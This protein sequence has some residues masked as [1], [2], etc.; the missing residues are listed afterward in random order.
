MLPRQSPHHRCLSA[1]T[2]SNYIV[3]PVPPVV[4]RQFGNNLEAKKR[5]RGTIDHRHFGGGQRN[6]DTPPGAAGW[7]DG[8]TRARPGCSRTGTAPLCAAD[9]GGS[10]RVRAHADRG[11]GG[12]AVVRSFSCF[13]STVAVLEDVKDRIGVGRRRGPSQTGA[14]RASRCVRSSVCC[15]ERRQIPSFSEAKTEGRRSSNCLRDGRTP[16]SRRCICGWDIPRVYR[17]CSIS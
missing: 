7:T 5:E 14:G 1:I 12:R 11:Q 8:R 16:D 10:E 13:A 3:Q 6:A 17:L 15:S 4:Q 9:R 2:R